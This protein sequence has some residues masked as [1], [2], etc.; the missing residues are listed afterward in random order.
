MTMISTQKQYESLTEIGA[1]I[2]LLLA[3]SDN[4]ESNKLLSMR[5]V[6]YEAVS[7]T[8]CSKDMFKKDVVERYLE[9]NNKLIRENRWK[10]IL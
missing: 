9:L 7:D 5:E 2:H 8:G 10:I 3:Q 6:L 1:N 4:I